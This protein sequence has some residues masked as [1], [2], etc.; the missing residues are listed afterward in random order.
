MK[1]GMAFPYRNPRRSPRKKF[2]SGQ[3]PAG[4]GNTLERVG[5]LRETFPFPLAHPPSDA[6]AES[7]RCAESTC[8]RREGRAAFPSAPLLPP[9]RISDAPRARSRWKERTPRPPSSPA[10]AAKELDEG[11]NFP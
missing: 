11:E 8:G 2:Q 10:R 3:V 1:D 7:F 4:L 9:F 5:N 6:N